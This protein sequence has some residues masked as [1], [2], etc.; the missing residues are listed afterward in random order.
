MTRFHKTP[1]AI[2]AAFLLAAGA[3]AA[4]PGPGPGS[5]FGKGHPGAGGP[6]GPAMMI[7][8]ALTEMRDKLA[9]DTSQQVQWQAAVDQSRAAHQQARSMRDEAKAKIDAELAKA[10]P[11]LAALAVTLDAVEEQGRAL[12]KS[13]RDAWLR[14]YATMRADQKA[15]VRDAVKARLDRVSHFRERMHGAGFGRTPS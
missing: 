5:G 6:P 3:V 2:A 13:S 10:E 1:V 7:E 12:R 11:D 4:G 9:L 15:L 14:L 8:L